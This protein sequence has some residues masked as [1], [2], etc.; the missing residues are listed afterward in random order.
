MTSNDVFRPHLGSHRTVGTWCGSTVRKMC[1]AGVVG[2]SVVL[3]LSSLLRAD[4]ADQPG[5]RPHPPLQT[6]GRLM[7]L[8]WSLTGG[9]DLFPVLNL[10][11]TD[12]VQ[13]HLENKIS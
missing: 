1:S 2:S 12:R 5:P 6:R 7:L 3:L 4:G 10:E 9:L 8:D 13:C 11:N